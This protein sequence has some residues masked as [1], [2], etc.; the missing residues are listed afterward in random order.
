M[1]FVRFFFL[2]H[3]TN[4]T[5]TLKRKGFLKDIQSASRCYSC[6]NCGEKFNKNQ[7]N[8]EVCAHP[9]YECQKTHTII[10]GHMT[11]SKKCV[12][13]GACGNGITYIGLGGEEVKFCCKDD[14]CNS[15]NIL[16]YS[17]I[18][19]IFIITVFFF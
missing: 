4:L 18:L 6:E 5:Q 7:V 3:E 12:E 17:I 19:I 14:L 10:L 9:H 2:S 8:T 13:P 15:T 11:I 16:E 1:L